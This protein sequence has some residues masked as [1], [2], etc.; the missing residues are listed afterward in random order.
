MTA[1]NLSLMLDSKRAQSRSFIIVKRKP[2]FF[3]SCDRLH[4]FQFTCSLMKR[5]DFLMKMAQDVGMLSQA[6]TQRRIL[7]VGDHLAR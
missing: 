5:K 7:S 1:R 6:V 2:M 4:T 3:F